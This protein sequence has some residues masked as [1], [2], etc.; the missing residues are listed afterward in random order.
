VIQSLAFVDL[1][2]GIDWIKIR[3]CQSWIITNRLLYFDKFKI[4]R[5]VRCAIM[6]TSD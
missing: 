5:L 6:L 1:V 4:L 3:K 2:S